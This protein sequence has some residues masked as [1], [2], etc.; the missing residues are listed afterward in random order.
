MRLDRHR[1]LEAIESGVR[2]A[3]ELDVED[4]IIMKNKLILIKIKLNQKLIKTFFKKKFRQHLII[5]DFFH[6]LKMRLG[7]LI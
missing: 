3:L 2:Y 7:N 6:L 4:I 5:R 1:L